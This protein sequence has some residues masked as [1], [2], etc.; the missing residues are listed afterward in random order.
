MML[1]RLFGFDPEIT[2]VRT[3]ILAGTTSFLTMAY[4]LA[5]NPSLFGQLEGMPAESVFTATALAAIIG[6]LIMA[7]VAKMPFGIAPG[8]GPNTFF[9]FTICALG[10]GYSWK[11][12]LTAVFIEG[13]ILLLMTATNL[14]NKLVTVMPDSIKHSIS[15]GIGLFITFVGFQ[16][17]G[18]TVP[19]TNTMIRFGTITSG[20]GLL[21]IIGLV[22]TAVLIIRNVKGAMLISILV[23]TLIGIPMGLTDIDGV[24]SMPESPAPIFC[25]IQWDQI[26]SVEMLS[27]VLSFL[28]IDLFCLTGSAFGVYSKGGFTD[29]PGKV[30]GLKGMFYADS[31]GTICSSILGTSS[32]CTYVESS[33]GVS[34]GGRSGLTAFTIAVGFAIAMFFS[35]AFLAIPEAATAAPLIVLGTM[36]FSDVRKLNMEDMSEAIPAF[37]TII[38]M[39]LAYSIADG[40]L[41][42]TISYVI[43][44]L[45]SG[46]Y[47]KLSV[48]MYILAAVFSLK[49]LL[50]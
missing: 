40:I 10:A 24:V 8:M 18:I 21:A 34:Q 9:V 49:Y 39:P 32:S 36:M 6:S 28:F 13:I 46:K 12:A 22:I 7:F 16:N 42:G 5:I 14:R 4:I 47:K 45:L 33:T 43:I 35:P 30:R 15:I 25:Q 29:N 38:T 26:F 48:G 17:A 44:N 23:T 41:L 37:I 31:I 11:L 19:D 50:I 27:I 20:S 1:K 3:E 2:T